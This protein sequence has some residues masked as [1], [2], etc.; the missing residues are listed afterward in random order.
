MAAVYSGAVA[1]KAFAAPEM[2]I[3]P[4]LMS[5]A[6]T[7]STTELH[8]LDASF[9]NLAKFVGP[10]V[11][12]IKSHSKRA[13][14]S[15]GVR[16]PETSGE[17]SGFLFT[18]DGY[19]AT[20]DHVVGTADSV[21]VTL[22]DGR[23]FTGKVTRAN[24]IDS[25]IAL[26]KIDGKDL[27]Y[28]SFADSST[29]QPGQFAM[30]I[31]AP[32]GLENTVTVG[33]ISALGRS[34]TRIGG[35]VYTDMLQTDAAIN[36]GNSGGPLVNVDGQVIGMNTAI[37]SPTGGSNG[38]GFA[39]PSNQVKLIENKLVTNGKVVRSMLGVYP[40]DIKEFERT[41][42]FPNGGAKVE[43]IA[44]EPAQSAGF[45]KDDVIVKVGTMDVHGQEDLRNAMIEYAPGTTVPIEVIRN[46]DRK[47]INVKLLPWKMPKDATQQLDEG[48]QQG[49]M[50]QF[51]FRGLPFGQ[52]PFRGFGNPFGDDNSDQAPQSQTPRT[53][54]ALLGVQVQDIDANGA[55][56]QYHIPSRVSGAVI[57]GV[58][59]DSVAARIGMQQGDVI[60]SLNGKTV[61]NAQDLK[62]AMKGINWGSTAHIAY[63]R[64]GE[65]STGRF[66]LDVKFE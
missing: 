24:D 14:T 40:S 66:E 8:N 63:S 7:E 41:S 59:P 27:P 30:A 48:G 64:Y 4:R 28:I 15:D 58:E 60:T 42:H 44:G 11:V 36:M 13:M 6:S 38:I 50:R 19:I 52:D 47:T 37:Y 2:Q 32:F 26:V 23:E 16:M 62:D 25:D 35:H 9:Q 65:G 12:D 43:K 53:G 61:A 31:G 46:G 56:S 33:H 54:H 55:R 39:I 18:P 20:N 45:Q 57:V 29:V 49:P 3:K 21:S 5:S 22:K 51:P 10:A 34:D 17:G 1:P